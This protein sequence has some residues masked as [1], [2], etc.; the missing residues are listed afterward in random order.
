[1]QRAEKA[2]PSGGRNVGVALENGKDSG[3]GGESWSFVQ[4]T[5]LAKHFA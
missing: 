1:M 4:S 5:T 2:T 3:K